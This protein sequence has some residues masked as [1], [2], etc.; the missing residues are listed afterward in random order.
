MDEVEDV[1]LDPTS[2]LEPSSSSGRR[3]AFGYT[4]AGRYLMA[5]FDEIDEW[6]VYPVTAYD[7]PEP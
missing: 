6:T 3:V 2:A 5:A 7:V 4:S 1:L